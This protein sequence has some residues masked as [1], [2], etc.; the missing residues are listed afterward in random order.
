M[1]TFKIGLIISFSLLILA[2]NKPTN[3]PVSADTSAAIEEKSELI[4]TTTETTLDLTKYGIANN[5]KNILGGLNIGDEA[6][7]FKMLDQDGKEKSLEATLLEGPVLLVFLRAEWC[8]FCVRHLKEFQDNIE[9]IHNAGEVKVIAVSPQKRSYMQE[10]HQENQ[11]SFPILHDE[12][13]STMKNY[14]VFFHVTDKYNNY[15]EEAKGNR[16]EVFNGDS[17]PVMPIPATYLIG[18]DKI[19][20]YVHYDP[21]YKKRSNVKEVINLL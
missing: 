8:S 21:N 9:E 17:E 12:D 1:A 19:I 3:K 4:T 18:Q 20:K 11:F 5:P 6:P 10:F 14:K 2:C 16:I 15:I 7:D 13:H